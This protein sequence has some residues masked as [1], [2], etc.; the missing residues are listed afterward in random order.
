M[1]DAQA[2][3]TTAGD[4]GKG[5][6][7]E[8]ARW[9]AEIDLFE[10]QQKPMFVRFDKIVKRY[11]NE[12]WRDDTPSATGIDANGRGFAMF[13]ANVETLKPTIYAQPPKAD[14]QRRW[15]DKDPVARVAATT[16][17]RCLDYFIDTENFRDSTTACRDDYLI[18]GQGTQWHRY[19]PHFHDVTLRTPVRKVGAQGPGVADQGLQ[20]TNNSEPYDPDDADSEYEAQG[21]DGYKPLG[22][23]EKPQSDAKGLYI[24]RTHQEIQSEEWVPDYVYWSDFGWTPGARTWAEVYCVWRKTYLTRDELCDRFGDELGKKVRLDY[25]PG[26][27][28]ETGEDGTESKQSFKKAT[29]YEIWNS[30]ARQT[31]WVSRSYDGDLLDKRAYP[32]KLSGRFPCQKPIWATQTNG[33]IA[34]VPDYLQYQDQAQ[35]MDT[36]TQRIYVLM[37]TIR[38]RYLYAGNMTDLQN[39]LQ[40]SGDNDGTPVASDLLALMGGDINK[41]V[42]FFPI[43]KMVEALNELMAARE[44]VKQDAYE[45]TGI[46]DI[47]RGATD[48]NETLGAQQI[49]AQTGAVRIR[50]RQKNFADFVRGALRIGADIIVNHFQAETIADIADI[51]TIPEAM[52]IKGPDGEWHDPKEVAAMIAALQKQQQASMMASAGPPAAPSQSGAPPMPGGPFVPQAQPPG[53]GA[54]IP[55][56]MPPQMMPG[57]PQG[58]PV[59]PMMPSMGMGHNGGPPMGPQQTLGEAAIALLKDPLQRQFRIDIETDSTIALDEAT[60]KSARVEFVTAVGQFLEAATQITA[61]PMGAE[62][63]PLLGEILL[64]AVRG[65]KV[66]TQLEGA[67]ESAIEALQEKAKNPPPPPP[68]PAM[69]KAQADAAAVQAQAANDRAKT[70]GEL[71]IQQAE[72]QRA[73]EAHQVEMAHETVARQ[74]EIAVQQQKAVNDAQSGRMDLIGKGIDLQ[75]KHIDLQIAE[76][77]LKEAKK[78][79]GAGT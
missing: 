79:N 58:F 63:A 39:L 11:R 3:V 16:L 56:Q 45:I 12:S 26:K 20:T 17:E 22:P 54:Q 6:S 70:Q 37:D 40:N 9:I 76:A 2:P 25:S 43:E 75:G 42:W 66:G 33:Q 23:K 50:D 34:A 78:P 68:D 72:A 13:W 38:V 7:G 57:V 29:V 10:S 21:P 47:I 35:E 41:A 1:T 24:N 14:V 18:V 44:R 4:Y 55:P 31:Y 67:I 74:G 61:T 32:I 60:E 53:S 51:K 28:A 8:N 48:P 73:G 36:L 64:F 27:N 19:V 71:A 77:R 69:V 59:S 46:S 5:P 49:K 65:F 52:H 30:T 62:L 15:K